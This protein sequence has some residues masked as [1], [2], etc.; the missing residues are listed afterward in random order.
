MQQGF[1]TEAD[2]LILTASGT[3]ALEATVVNT[4]SP[5]DSVLSVN[6][7]VFGDRFAKI[8]RAYGADVTT[9]AVDMA[10]RRQPDE[11]GE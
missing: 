7:G 10:R 9:L 3:G 4:L 2:V 1:Q 6:I 5:G 11:V 8:A